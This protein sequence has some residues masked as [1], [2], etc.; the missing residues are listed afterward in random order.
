MPKGPK[1]VRRVVHHLLRQ[2]VVRLQQEFV[3]T[4]EQL[5]ERAQ[6]KLAER[7]ETDEAA[8]P[9]GTL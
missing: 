1:G 5:W 3:T 6:A 9:D 4:P 2:Y 8:S 7:R